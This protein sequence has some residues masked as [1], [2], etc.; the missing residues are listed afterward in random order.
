MA[1]SG[2]S[3]TINLIDKN[4]AGFGHEFQNDFDWYHS[5]GK[6]GNNFRYFI[7]NIRNTYINS[8]LHYSSDQYKN[9]IKSFAVDRP[10]FS[11]FAKWAAGISFMQQNR[12]DSILSINY[13][14]VQQRFKF[15]E[16]DFWA[17]NAIQLFKGNSENNRTTNFISAIRYLR[18]RYLE[19]PIET[20]DPQ[21]Y[22]SNEDFYLASVGISTRKYVQDKFI[23]KYGVTEDVPIGKVFSITSGYQNK[24]NAGRMYLGARV[25]LGYYYSWGYLA[26]NFEYGTFIRAS[27]AQQGNFIASVNYFTG[28]IE[29]GKW[30]FR[31]FVKP[32]I[33]FGINRFSSDSLTLNDGYGLDGFNS[34]ELTGTSRLLFTFQTQSY[35][36]WNFI[37][38]RFGPY[39]ICSAGMLGNEETSFQNSKVYTQFG[40]G[41]LIKN[42]NLVFKTFQIS[43]A[44]YPSIPGTADNV[45][46]LNPF[47][48]TD[49]GFR[50]FEIGKPATTVFH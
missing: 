45:F 32:E 16:Q 22:F 29:I 12:Q 4:F 31:H 13:L 23:F 33:I 3:L 19:K 36:P 28:L 43:V 1:A 15:N 46:K 47:R 30:K 40:F 50:D 5:T 42:E 41:V 11:P 2:T 17:G 24:N 38:F 14:P 48:T 20:L 25:S 49:F 7:P 10:F 8:T 39:I 18:I 6:I 34:P 27:Q 37:G 35:A 21:H 26:T 9:S 44:F